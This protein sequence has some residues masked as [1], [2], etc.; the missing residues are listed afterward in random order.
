MISAVYILYRLLWFV[1]R[2][3]EAESPLPSS[4]QLFYNLLSDQSVRNGPRFFGI[5]T[6]ILAALD[7]NAVFL[8][9]VHRSC[10]Y[11][12]IIFLFFQAKF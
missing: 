7:Q 2:Q 12:N 10:R 1:S 8:S 4:F 3:E 11:Y 6:V 5:K 9:A